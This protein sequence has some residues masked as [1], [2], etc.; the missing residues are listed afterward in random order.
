MCF[1]FVGNAFVYLNSMKSQQCMV[2]MEKL[3]YSL[4]TELSLSLLLAVTH[5][6][7]RRFLWLV[8]KER[9]RVSIPYDCFVKLDAL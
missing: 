3:K 6:H 4:I 2:V 1:S 9:K 7:F 5:V 8:K